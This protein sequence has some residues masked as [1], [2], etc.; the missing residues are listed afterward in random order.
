MV[1]LFL[2]PGQ[3]PQTEAYIPQPLI[4]ENPT[5]QEAV[6]KFATQYQVNEQLLL[7]VMH[8]ESSGNQNAIGD[9][10]KAR[11]IFQFH[12]PTFNYFEKQLGE[13]LDYNSL[14]DQAKL[15]A[16]MFSKGESY[17]KHWTCY[18]KVLK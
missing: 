4:W 17:R 18:K 16:Y 3:P 6:H 12:E 7:K 9:G 15:A 13:D 11:N 10:G 5:P 1:P 14:H 2:I 8:C